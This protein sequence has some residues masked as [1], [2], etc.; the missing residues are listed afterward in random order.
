MTIALV[1][2]AA[3]GRYGGVAVDGD[4]RVLGFGVASAPAVNGGVDVFSRAALDGLG[5][6]AGQAASL[7]QDLFPAMLARRARVY[8]TLCA[9]EFLDIGVPGDYAR[10]AAILAG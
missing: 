10:A 9:G 8:A 1:P 2:K 6:G 4:G 5:W 7:E 3:E